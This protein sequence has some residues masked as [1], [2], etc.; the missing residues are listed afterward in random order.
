MTQLYIPA[1]FPWNNAPPQPTR[2]IQ[3]RLTNEQVVNLLRKHGLDKKELTKSVSLHTASTIIRILNAAGITETR[4]DRGSAPYTTFVDDPESSYAAIMELTWRTDN[5][6][7]AHNND[8]GSTVTVVSAKYP[9]HP[10][11]QW[12]IKD[13]E[14]AWRQGWLLTEPECDGMKFEY[15]PVR[16]HSN[17]QDRD[18][19]VEDGELWDV[20]GGR[21]VRVGWIPSSSALKE[22]DDL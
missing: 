11:M 10:G 2:D 18:L 15:R 3:L 22:L 21:R 14:H 20:T 17:C 1:T 19:L 9:Y 16:T 6:H 7:K 8:Y 4:Q 5:Q 13:V 12:S